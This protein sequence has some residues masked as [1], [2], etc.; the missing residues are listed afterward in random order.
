MKIVILS[1]T[2]NKHLEIKNMPKGDML[3]HA[4]DFTGQGRKHEVESFLQW[5]SV[6]D[7]KYKIFIAGN[8][9]WFF[10]QY[11]EDE[12]KDLLCKYDSNGSVYYLQDSMVEIEGL[13]IWGSPWTPRF[14]NWAFNAST[15]ELSRKWSMIPHDADVVI[16][17]GPMYGVGDKAK[18]VYACSGEKF[19]GYEHTGCK[20]LFNI[21]LKNVGPK[22]HVCGHI[23]EGYGVYELE[24]GVTS[25]NASIL[26]ERYKLVNKPQVFVLEKNSNKLNNI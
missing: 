15:D 6:Q 22:L 25:V 19:V 14:Y 18:R 20:A 9:D 11:K 24:G 12:V 2:H 23:H 8:H 16:T 5:F 1:D 10:H 13:K 17:H 21:L 26:D 7:Y 3:I 4:G